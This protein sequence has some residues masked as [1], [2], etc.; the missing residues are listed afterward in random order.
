MTIDVFLE[1]LP[2]ANMTFKCVHIH[3]AGAQVWSVGK[4]G[5]RRVIK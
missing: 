2:D 4:E 5:S 1:H 3:L